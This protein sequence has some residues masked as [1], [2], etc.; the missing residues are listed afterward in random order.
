MAKNQ[1]MDNPALEKIRKFAKKKLNKKYPNQ[2]ID[3]AVSDSSGFMVHFPS[4]KVLKIEIKE[5]K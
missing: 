5:I 3:Y 4:G 2:V 1:P